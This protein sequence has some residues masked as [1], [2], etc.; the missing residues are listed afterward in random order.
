MTRSMTMPRTHAPQ[1]DASSSTP[2]RLLFLFLLSSLALLALSRLTFLMPTSIDAFILRPSPPQ[3]VKCHFSR[4]RL[5]V[6][7]DR[8]LVSS[9]FRV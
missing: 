8:V 9:V 3:P 2:Y 1:T 5:N 4:H 6:F 7:F